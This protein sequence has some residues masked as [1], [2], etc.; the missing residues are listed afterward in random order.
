M[1]APVNL[2]RLVAET[3]PTYLVD[4]QA[5]LIIKAGD[6][7]LSLCPQDALELIKFIERTGYQA[8]ANSLVKGA[9]Q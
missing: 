3:S 4:N 5:T 1:N 7:T 6:V 9:A 8:H 2:H